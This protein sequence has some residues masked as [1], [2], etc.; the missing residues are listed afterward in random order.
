M[1]GKFF[2][3]SDL[4]WQPNY[5]GQIATHSSP[6]VS[7]AEKLMF[8]D[9]KMEPGKCHSFHFHPN[10]EEI[11]YVMEGTIQQWIEQDSVELSAGESA[12]IPQGVIHA[13][14]NVSGKPARLLAILGPCIGEEGYEVTDV[15]EQEPWKALAP[16]S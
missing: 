9:I 16:I 15:F 13:T 6:S 12:F 1:N 2:K 8:L 7:D 14:F 3:Q 5:M 10:Q 4:A 11:I